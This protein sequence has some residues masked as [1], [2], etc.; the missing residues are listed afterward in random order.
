MTKLKKVVATVTVL[1]MLGAGGVA[2]AAASTPADIASGLTGKTVEEL[3]NERAAGKTY[4]TIAKEAGKLEEFKV[5]MMEQ[6]KATLEQR[7]K[8]GKLTTEKAEEILNAIKE[9]QANCDGNGSAA[10]GKKYGV[11]FGQ[12]GGIGGGTGIGNGKG[13]GNGQNNGYGK[14]MGTGMG[15]GMNR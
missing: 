1:G 8:D 10:I 13:N 7:V 9:N 12:G 5:Q 6:K 3:R 2:Y 14:G 15:R 11:G 4:G